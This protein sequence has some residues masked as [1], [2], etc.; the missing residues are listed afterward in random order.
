MVASVQFHGRRNRTSVKAHHW[1]PVRIATCRRFALGR[2]GLQRHRVEPMEHDDDYLI[3]AAS[4]GDVD[5]DELERTNPDAAR[6]IRRINSLMINGEDSKAEFLRLCRLLFDVGKHTASEYLLRRN[7]DCYEGAALYGE[8]FGSAKEDEFNVAIDAF[9]VQFEVELNHIRDEA[10]LVRYYHAVN[11]PAR[12]DDLRLLSQPC[13]IK[14]GYIERDKIEADIMLL[15]P[16]RDVFKARDCLL[17]FFVN[18]VWE[19]VDPM[20]D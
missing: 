19:I 14:F 15:D 8:L 18:G 16:G 20:S 17:L 2:T 12:F 3:P 10:F 13:E 5:F 6:E 7:L 1:S 9:R 11:C 4:I